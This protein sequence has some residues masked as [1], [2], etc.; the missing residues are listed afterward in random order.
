MG[1]CKCY[2]GPNLPVA[3]SPGG[4]E[5]RARLFSNCPWDNANGT[6]SSA[7]LVDTYE[8]GATGLRC[9]S[10]PSR[11]SPSYHRNNI[12]ELLGAPAGGRAFGRVRAIGTREILRLQPGLPRAE[13]PR[14][15][16]GYH[17][18]VQGLER[19]SYHLVRSGSSACDKRG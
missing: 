7:H 8:A 10:S 16:A 14:S 12:G 17:L 15:R 2:A 18:Q 4:V 19:G 1:H 6:R 9:P 3:A 5:Y 13:K 11:E